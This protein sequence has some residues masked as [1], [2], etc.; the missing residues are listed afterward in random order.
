LAFKARSA[1]EADVP[2]TG[3]AMF[4][5]AETETETVEVVKG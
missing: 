2:Y 5:F 4:S 3:G 1:A